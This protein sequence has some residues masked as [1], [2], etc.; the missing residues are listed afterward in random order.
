MK[1]M[2][3]KN[4]LEKKKTVSECQKPKCV[5]ISRAWKLFSYLYSK[6]FILLINKSSIIYR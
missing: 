3:P 6:C 2:R 1:N 4:G 5:Y